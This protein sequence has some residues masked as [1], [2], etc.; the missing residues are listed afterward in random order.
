MARFFIDRPVFAWVIAIFIMIVGVFS[1]TRLPVEQY[2]N[3]SSPNITI[4]FVYLGANAQTV[5]DS[6]I[7]IIEESMN[8][9]DNIDYVTASAYSNGQ[10][11][12]SL[13]FRSGTDAD[14]AQVDVQNKLA[15]VEPRLPQV[16]RNM[17]VTVSQANSG[18][19]LFATLSAE[20]GSNKDINEISDYAVRS[21]KPVIQKIE[22]VGS[23]Q[24][25]GSELAMRVWVSP[26]KLKSYGLSFADVSKAIDEQNAQVTAGS[27]GASPSVIGQQYTVGINVKGQISDVKGFENIA[28]RYDTSGATV[29]LRDVAVVEIAKQSYAMGMRV[30]GQPALGIGVQLSSDGNAVLVADAVRAKMQ[31]IAPFFP[32]GIAWDIPYDSSTFVKISIE[33]VFYT[34]LEAIALVFVVMFLFLQNIRYTIIPTI[35]VPISLLGAVALMQPMGLSIN[36]LTMFAMVLVIGIVVDD[37][38]V[39]VEN[40]ERLMV[41]EGLTPYQAA[42]KSMG[43]ITGAV[44]GITLVLISVFLPMAF[45]DGVN[46][47]IYRQFSLVMGASIGFSAFLALSLTPSLCATL[48]KPAREDHH[49]KKGFFGLFNRLVKS[50]TRGYQILVSKM[51]RHNYL[52]MLAFVGLTAGAVYLF[53]QIRSSFLPVEDQGYLITS[54]QLPSGATDERTTAAIEKAEQVIL[55][56]PEV[57]NAVSILGFSFSGQ[58]QNMAMGFT[59]LK[60]WKERAGKGQSA[61]EIAQRLMGQLMPINEVFSF[62]LNPPAIPSLGTSDGLTFFLQDRNGQGHKALLNARNQLLGMARKSKVLGN[63]RPSGLPD[64]TQITV[65]I[66]RNAAFAQDVSLPSIS[67]TLGT[68]LGGAYIN[69]FPNRGRMQRV[70][71]MAE[72]KARMQPDDILNL[73]VMNSKGQLVPLSSVASV[74]W[75]KGAEQLTTYN[76]YGAIKIDGS[77]AAGY[78][79]GQAM[80]AIEQLASKLP[81]GFAVEWSGQSLE[82]RRAGN[83]ELFVYALSAIAVFLCLAALYNSWSIPFAV[84]M[85]VPLGVLGVTLGNYFRGF[86]NDI[87]FKIGMIT[88]MGLSAKNAILI[89]EFAKDLQEQGSSRVRAAISAAALRFRPIIMTSLAFI[90]GVVPLYF[91]T[92]ASSASQRAIGT[93]VL[94]GML[95][96][97]LLAIFFVP[98]YYVVV[99]KLFGGGHVKDKYASVSATA[100]EE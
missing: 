20:K 82:E 13:T 53:G 90:A 43:Q 40:V 35:V 5:Q 46:G 29:R 65:T 100:N 58:G 78:S 49:T 57:E 9:V 74:K 10:G 8:T 47:A 95:V 68:A 25:F 84:L 52:M 17:G 50:I 37:A 81:K 87:Y 73:T 18:F 39:V 77:A 91:S 89:I 27:L 19:L 61:P 3:V 72:P 85:V 62:T 97:T 59:T 67:A 96:G 44:I 86:D 36:V 1:A 14:M 42:H 7:S 41:E 31:D 38:I 16:V 94:W 26:D 69:D 11:S 54:Y 56:Q 45:L 34:L 4:S 98:I 63:L 60:D 99:R 76:G 83:S 28:I 21:V 32:E 33:K 51:V 6:V 71:V 92:G 30:N 24:V 80:Q 22:G 79:S 15:Q 23:V 2:P 70:Y 66:D 48:L 64:A 88:V 93:S 12:L 55:K 75:A